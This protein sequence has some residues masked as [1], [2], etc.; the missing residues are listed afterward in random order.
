MQS[1]AISQWFAGKDPV[2][3]RVSQ[4][5]IPTLVADGS[6]DA[7]DPAANDRQLAALIPD[8]TLRFYPDAGH[9]FLMQDETEF[10]TQVASFTK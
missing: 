10:A 8:A 3:P 1:A 2:G 6:R 7:L 5:T 4:L 9:A